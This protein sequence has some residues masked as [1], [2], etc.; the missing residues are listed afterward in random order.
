M[1]LSVNGATI[2]AN[3][4]V[5]ITAVAAGSI[6]AGGTLLSSAY[7]VPANASFILTVTLASGATSS[8]LQITRDNGTF[9][10]NL[11]NGTALTASNEFNANVPVKTGDVVQLALVTATTLGQSEFFF[12]PE[13]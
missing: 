6:A 7:T 1:G 12:V 11:N 10:G 9:Y 5:S 4:P 8:V 13:Q 2:T 3:A